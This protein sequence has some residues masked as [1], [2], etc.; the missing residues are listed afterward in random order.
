[1]SSPIKKIFDLVKKD[2]DKNGGV[3]LPAPAISG[4]CVGVMSSLRKDKKGFYSLRR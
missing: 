1:M 3:E 4:F 2:F